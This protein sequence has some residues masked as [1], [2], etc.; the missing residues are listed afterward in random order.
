MINKIK[1]VIEKHQDYIPIKV[2]AELLAVI[3]ETEEDYC[4][5]REQ[6]IYGWMYI[7]SHENRST[8]IV[9]DL[10]IR[11]YCDVCGKKIKVVRN[12]PDI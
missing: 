5:W 2:T 10:P 9:D 8:R 11:P 6:G 1:D 7:S 3:D 4:L 12:E